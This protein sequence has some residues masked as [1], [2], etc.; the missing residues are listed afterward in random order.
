MQKKYKLK[1][2]QQSY[3]SVRQSGNIRPAR[4]IRRITPQADLAYAGADT[5]STS[6]PAPCRVDGGLRPFSKVR[7]TH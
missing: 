6:Y 4:F 1:K 5:P 7:N 3:V 2:K